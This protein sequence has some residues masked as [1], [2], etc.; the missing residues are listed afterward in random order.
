MASLNA[1]PEYY[2]AEG[3]YHDAKTAED[4][5]AA[6]EEMLRY[7]PKHKAAHSILMEIK[8]KISRVKKEQALE[9]RKA[10]QRKA[11]GGGPKD[12]IKRAGA[13]QVVLLGFA[14]SGKSFLLNA[15]TNGRARV[16]STEK[17]FETTKVTPGMMEFNKIQIQI[18]DTPSIMEQ[19]RARLFALARNADLTLVLIDPA[20]DGSA[21]K[22]FFDATPGRKI[23]LTRGETLN[24]R[25]LKK[26]IFDEVG[27]IR[28]FTK[29]PRGE[30]DY[31][32]P[33]ALARGRNTVADAA[34]E[35]H[36]EL[37]EG[38]KYARVWGSTKFPGQQVSGSYELRDGDVVELHLK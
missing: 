21:E 17:P 37:A 18:L 34:R 10:A 29:N 19:N 25:A 22:T 23:F 30:T 27:V 15:L 13:A 9:A 5:L 38:L 24:I 7:C 28:V 14:N 3:R 20:G 6:L 31:E 32:R 26:K 4:K 11:G 2:A 35:I 1:G 12:F 36:K 33:V 16:A 8:N